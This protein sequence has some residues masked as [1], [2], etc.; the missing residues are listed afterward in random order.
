MI[1]SVFLHFFPANTVAA[2]PRPKILDNPQGL[3][4]RLVRCAPARVSWDEKAVQ[5]ISSLAHFPVHAY[6][7]CHGQ[8]GFHLFP[9]LN[10]RWQISAPGC[11]FFLSPSCILFYRRWERSIG[12]LERPRVKRH[13]PNNIRPPKI[14]FLTM[15]CGFAPMPRCPR[16][17]MGTPIGDG[18]SSRD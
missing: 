16:C 15:H 10:F 12:C 14:R 1:S 3:H 17:R 13:R 11:I 9:R 6:A 5:L 7:A 4:Y 8:R 18:A 2:F